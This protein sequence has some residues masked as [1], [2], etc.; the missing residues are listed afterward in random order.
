MPRTIHCGQGSETEP[1][2]Q[3]AMAFPSDKHADTALIDKIIASYRSD[4][5]TQNIDCAFLPNRARTIKIIELFRRLIFP[6]FFDET[7]VTSD[8]LRD[9]VVDLLRAIHNTLYEQVRQTL[10]NDRQRLGKEMLACSCDTQAKTITMDL[11]NLIPD[12]RMRLGL[13]VQ[14]A[15]DGDSATINTDE[16]IFCYPGIDAV[17]IYRLAHELHLLGVPLLARI[18]GEYAHNET[19]ID[20][21]PGARIGAPFFIDHGTGVVIGETTQIGQRVQIYQG[22]TLGALAPNDSETWRGRKRHPT[23]EDDVTIYGG[24]VILGGETTIGR[25][26][27]IGGTV[28]LTS[29]VPAFHKVRI[30]GTELDISPSR[31]LR[32]R[33]DRRTQT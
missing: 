26:S 32:R 25:G 8:N 17:F 1:R 31:R 23:I 13:D 22:V 10:Y 12:V 4:D 15:Y 6:G 14:A 27:E 7:R 20:I 33:V 21:H 29:S 3:E 28:F 5:R 19:G 16:T 2:I 9:R 11:L 30:K 24:A 18:M